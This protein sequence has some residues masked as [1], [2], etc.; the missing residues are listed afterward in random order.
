[1]VELQVGK[2]LERRRRG[3]SQQL[4]SIFHSS[5]LR[6]NFDSIRSVCPSGVQSVG[7]SGSPARHVTSTLT[8][9]RSMFPHQLRLKGQTLLSSRTLPTLLT[10][11]GSSSP[12]YCLTANHMCIHLRCTEKSVTC[13]AVIPRAGIVLQ[14]PQFQTARALRQN[15]LNRLWYCG[16]RL[17]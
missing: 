5:F 13:S 2:G 12:S 17:R 8:L 7:A 11:V 3:R 9:L 1:M 10:G 15:Q 16:A 6:S 14:L 4:S